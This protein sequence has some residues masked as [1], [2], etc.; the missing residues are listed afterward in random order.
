MRVRAVWPFEFG[1]WRPRRLPAAVKVTRTGW[2]RL[3]RVRH[4]LPATSGISFVSPQGHRCQGSG[5]L[6]QFLGHASPHPQ[7]RAVWPDRLLTLG[8]FLWL[9]NESSLGTAWLRVSWMGVVGVV[10]PSQASRFKGQLAVC[11]VRG[12]CV[13]LLPDP[14]RE[15][16][17]PSGDSFLVRKMGPQLLPSLTHPALP[18]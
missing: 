6:P 8:L 4:S 7:V 3:G 16:G 13:R 15:T 11:R 10:A 18:A 2:A 9:R 17:S 5:P 1:Q 12:L 14:L